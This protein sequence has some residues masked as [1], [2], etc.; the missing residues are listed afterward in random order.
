[1]RADCSCDVG[2]GGSK[3]TNERAKL[4]RS[5]NSRNV[6]SELRK[7][8]AQVDPTKLIAHRFRLDQSLE[9][10]DTFANA[11]KTQALKVIIAA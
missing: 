7:K 1:M 11:A 3:G 9:A 2:P 8:G 10:Y 6:A 4:R 5:G